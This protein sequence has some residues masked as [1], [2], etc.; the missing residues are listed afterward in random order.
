[1]SSDTNEQHECKSLKTFELS[2]FQH[3]KQEDE[4]NPALTIKLPSP[5][6]EFNNGV[7]EDDEPTTPTSSD[8]KIPVTTSCPPAPRKPKSLPMGNKRKSRD[9]QRISVDL[10]VM[11]NAML[12]QPAVITGVD[13]L[14]G[15]DLG[16]GERAKKVKKANGAFN[17]CKKCN[18]TLSV[19]LE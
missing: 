3:Q 10:M 9:F 18:R 19:F 16:A 15:R 6:E 17:M 4:N 8:Q 13:I 12:V 11:I 1:M 2:Q 5:I 14:A 7:D